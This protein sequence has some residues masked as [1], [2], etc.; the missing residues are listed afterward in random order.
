MPSLPSI[1]PPTL[2]PGGL[3]SLWDGLSPHLIASIYEVVKTGDD[4]WG[5]T[6]QSDAATVLAPLTEASMEMVLNWQSPFE[7]A[8]PETKAPALM[9]ML[10]SGA[11]QPIVDVMLPGN[12]SGTKTEGSAQ[13][14]SNDFLKQFEG[15]TGIT[16]LN[17][18]QVFNGMPPV[19]IQVV[20]LFRAWRDPASEV[21]APFNKLMEWALPIELS[22]DGSL[23]ARAAETT[24]GDMGYVEALM[25]SRSPTRVAMKFKGRTYSPLVIESIGMPMNSPV[26]ANGQYVELA[27]PMTL[28]TLTAIDRKDWSNA[29]RVALM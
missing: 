13:Q 11:L 21:E 18:T 12:K 27:V 15:R 2:G 22:K 23:L 7:Q 10:Q 19:K 17:S 28:C 20:A 16:K 5:R 25:P 1:L 24:K 3:S 29:Q 14:K 6:A 9:A 4:S 26:D 8:G